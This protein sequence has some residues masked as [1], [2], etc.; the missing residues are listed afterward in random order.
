MPLSCAKAFSPTTA[1]L[2]GI[3]MPVM[4][5]TRRE[6]GYR[7]L[8]CTPV[9]TLKKA[10]RVLSAITTSSSAQLPARS[11]MPF[12]V[13]SIWRAPATTAVRLLATAM[14]RSSWQ[15]SEE[16]TSE[17]QSRRDLVCRLLLEKKKKKK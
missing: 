10:A 5:E 12:T 3:G 15:R 9:A 13:H 1:L 11:P 7:R 17:L 2:R 16:H 4:L 6:V 8:V 14:P